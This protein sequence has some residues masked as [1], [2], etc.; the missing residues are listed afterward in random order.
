[1]RVATTTIATSA[2]TCGGISIKAAGFDVC[3]LGSLKLIGL[4]TTY[5]KRFR[6][7]GFAGLG[8]MLSGWVNRLI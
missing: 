1:M 2:H 5:A 6:L 7:C 3:P 4:F 8:M